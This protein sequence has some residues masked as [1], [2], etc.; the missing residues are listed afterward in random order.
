MG[1]TDRG[2]AISGILEDLKRRGIM[3][4]SVVGKP[5]FQYPIQLKSIKLNDQTDPLTAFSLQ[6]YSS[7]ACYAALLRRRRLSCRVKTRILHSLG[8]SSLV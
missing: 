2:D 6:Q 8:Y 7:L 1:Q 4:L 3:A 5:V